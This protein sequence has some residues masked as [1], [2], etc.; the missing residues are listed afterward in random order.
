MPLASKRLMTSQTNILFELIYRQL[1]STFSIV[2]FQA[3]QQAL[4]DVKLP[5]NKAIVCGMSS[6][7]IEQLF[8]D[9]AEQVQLRQAIS[10]EQIAIMI[11]KELGEPSFGAW[12]C[13]L[14]DLHWGKGGHMFEHYTGTQLNQLWRQTGDTVHAETVN[15]PPMVQFL[16]TWFKYQ[17]YIYKARY[18]INQQMWHLYRNYPDDSQPQ[19]LNVHGNWCKVDPELLEV[20]MAFATEADA[21]T[22]VTTGQ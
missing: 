6:V 7:E 8:Y 4:C 18:N 21:V 1:Q 17:Q 5:E 3:F 11:Y 13:R 16:C 20:L 2:P 9:T 14:M 15:N 12:L 22:H 19:E 10:I